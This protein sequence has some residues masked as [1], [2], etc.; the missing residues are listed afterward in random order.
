MDLPVNEA[1][2]NCTT[3][4]SQAQDL[5]PTPTLPTQESQVHTRSKRKK[6]V[7]TTCMRIYIKNRGRSERIA[8]MQAKKFKF[9]V[10]GIGSTADK[11]FN[12]SEDEE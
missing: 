10:N 1:P 9:D 5:D 12:I 6:Q 3:K 2:K 8:N 11:A 4:E 7:A